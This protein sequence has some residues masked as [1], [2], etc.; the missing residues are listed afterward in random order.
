MHFDYEDMLIYHLR[1]LS[2][3]NNFSVKIKWIKDCE[4]KE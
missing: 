4:I 3:S 1:F 2:G